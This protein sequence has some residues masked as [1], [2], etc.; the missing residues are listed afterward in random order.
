MVF[1]LFTTSIVDSV[2]ILVVKSLPLSII[3]SFVY[4]LR[5]RT[6]KAGTAES[7]TI[8]SFQAFNTN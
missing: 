5:I 4:V 6:S 7:K 3:V 2:D 1:Q 8:P